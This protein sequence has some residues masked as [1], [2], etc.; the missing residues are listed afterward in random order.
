MERE[1]GLFGK[2]ACRL[3]DKI[4]RK[5]QKERRNKKRKHHRQKKRKEPE[6]KGELR[7]KQITSLRLKW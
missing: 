5:T 2:R 4:W 6:A 7:R 3:V 1:D